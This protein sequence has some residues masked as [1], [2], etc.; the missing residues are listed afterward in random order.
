[1]FGP[2]KVYIRAGV[3]IERSGTTPGCSICEAVSQG[4]T[5]ITES[6]QRGEDL[7]K[8]VRTAADRQRPRAKQEDDR[9][10]DRRRSPASE[11][12]TIQPM[13]EDCAPTESARSHRVRKASRGRSTA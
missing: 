3:E 7:S 11:T 8:R 10:R 5:R 2:R 6:M 4:S 12:E 13:Q 1:M 9:E